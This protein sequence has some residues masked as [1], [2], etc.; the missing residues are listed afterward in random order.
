DFSPQSMAQPVVADTADNHGWV[1]ELMAV[2]SEIE[3]RPTWLWALRQQVPQKLSDPND[4]A[5][6]T[7]IDPLSPPREPG[8]WRRMLPVRGRILHPGGARCWP[9]PSLPPTGLPARNAGADLWSPPALGGRPQP[10]TGPIGGLF[11]GAH[12]ILTRPN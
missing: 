5:R 10:T 4:R 7:H 6:M 3:W 11:P 9:S 1:A 12:Q 2:E 8:V